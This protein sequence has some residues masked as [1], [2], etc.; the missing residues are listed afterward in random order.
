MVLTTVDRETLLS[1][2]DVTSW[3]RT[4]HTANAHA[5]GFSGSVLNGATA[6]QGAETTDAYDGAV[7]GAEI[8]D[9]QYGAVRGAEVLLVYVSSKINLM[10]ACGLTI[11]SLLVARPW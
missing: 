9:E 3:A 7:Q 8:T 6:V 11:L 2:R 5:R 1:T 4:V 10:S